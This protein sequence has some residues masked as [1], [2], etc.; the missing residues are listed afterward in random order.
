MGFKEHVIRVVKQI[1]QGKVTTYG[2]V[3]TLAGMPRG[4]RLVGGILHFCTESNDLPWQ[5][6]I[7]REGFISTKCLEHPKQ[8][9]KALLASEGIE[10]SDDFTVDLNKYGWFGEKI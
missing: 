2:T 7:N 10:V 9:Q 6:I 4:G 5:R 8:A 1:P 3:A